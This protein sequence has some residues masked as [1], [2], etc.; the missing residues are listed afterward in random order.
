MEK[1]KNIHNVEEENCGCCGSHEHSECGCSDH[2]D[3]CGCGCEEMENLIVDLEDE[4]GNTVS[5]E[6]IDGFEYKDNNYIL[7]QNP[8]DGSIYLFKVVGEGE[9]ENLVVPDDKEFEEVSK[10]YESLED[11]DEE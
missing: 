7:V 3:A 2:E 4:N 5:C 11:E 1:D 10:Y 9:E 8:Q 6:M